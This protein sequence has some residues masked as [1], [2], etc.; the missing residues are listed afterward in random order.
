MDQIKELLGRDLF[1]VN[2][3]HATIGAAVVVVVVLWYF[4]GR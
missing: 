3:F 1:T 2:G 4:K